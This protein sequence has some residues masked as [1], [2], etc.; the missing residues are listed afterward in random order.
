MIKVQKEEYLAGEAR[1][2]LLTGMQLC[3][4]HSVTSE[5]GKVDDQ[6]GSQ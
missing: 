3:Q 4:C 6:S 2:G 5:P 1:L